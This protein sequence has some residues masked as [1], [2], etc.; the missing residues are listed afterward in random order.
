MRSFT[1]SSQVV[2]E[3]GPKFLVFGLPQ[4][5]NGGNEM[6]AI[7]ETERKVYIIDYTIDKQDVPALLYLAGIH[8]LR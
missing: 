4:Q 7:P 2:R 1:K 3:G 8:C 6:A 5:P